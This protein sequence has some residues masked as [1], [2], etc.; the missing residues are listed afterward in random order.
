V[1]SLNM[2]LVV[3]TSRIP[4]PGETILGAGDLQ[5]IPGGKGANQAYGSAQLGADVAMV[6]RVGSDI[7]GET[8]IQNLNKRLEDLSGRLGNFQNRITDLV[9][10]RTLMQ[11]KIQQMLSKKVKVRHKDAFDKEHRE[12]KSENVVSRR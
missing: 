9:K 7:F 10:E 8:L 6:G 3:R 12:E 11:K 4:K 5:M 1:G 2:D